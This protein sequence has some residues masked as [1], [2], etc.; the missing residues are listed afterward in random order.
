MRSTYR[1]IFFST[2]LVGLQQA[3]R[4]AVG[5]VQAKIVAVLLGATGTGSFGVFASFLN[6]AQSIFGLGLYGSG[7]RQVAAASRPESAVPP[8]RTIRTLLGLQTALAVL[9]GL[10][11]VWL[12]RPIS[13]WI[14]GDERSAAAIGFLAVS[15]VIALPGSGAMAALQGLRR[16]RALTAAVVLGMISGAVV[17]VGL[18]YR[19]REAGIAPAFLGSAACATAAAVLFLPAL[20]RNG[21]GPFRETLREAAVLVRL[22][23]GFLTVSLLGALSAFG[24]RALIVRRLGLEA[25]GYY[26]AGMMLAGFYAM[27]LAQAMGTDFL[28]RIS[29]CAGHREEFN[30]HVNEQIESGLVLAVPGILLCLAGAPLLLRAFYTAEFAT[31]AGPARWM[32]A[33]SLVRA[34][35]WPLNFVPVAL[36]RPGW[37]AISEAIHAITLFVFTAIGL[38]EFGLAGAGMACL[39]AALA[40]AAAQWFA[41]RRLTAISFSP[42]VRKLL[43]LLGPAAAVAFALA[44]ATRLP[45][46]IP[47]VWTVLIAIG[48]AAYALRLLRG[49]APA[50]GNVPS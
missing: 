42:A 22:G 29:G 32:L 11:T 8:E 21:R 6:L 43:G 20:R 24:V 45:V 37:M 2:G 49:R 25:V 48:C 26:Q 38:R 4:L 47:W 3:V 17:A 12:R 10:A 33:A 15:L 19:Y 36:N 31:A 46:W 50:A 5:V 9:G 41:A 34:A 40:L 30:R 35:A 1:E 27:A 44:P 16:L 13:R 28:P 39:A 23:V 7:V 18:I 14:F